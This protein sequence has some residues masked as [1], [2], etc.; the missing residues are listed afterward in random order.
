[1]YERL[2]KCAADF[3]DL[4]LTLEQPNGAP[5]VAAIRAALVASA[6]EIA[7]TPG[8]NELESN[9]LAKLYRGLL[10]ASRVLDALQEYRNTT[11]ASAEPR[12]AIGR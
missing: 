8:A 5:R 1:M 2:E 9:Q 6:E 12:T 4:K 7:A 3:N 10:A 11:Q